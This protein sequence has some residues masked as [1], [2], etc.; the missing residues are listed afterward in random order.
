MRHF[1][2]VRII[3]A[4]TQT[5]TD[6]NLEVRKAV[7]KSLLAQ[8][9]EHASKGLVVLLGDDSHSVWADAAK[10]ILNLGPK[11]KASLEEALKHKKR[12]VRTRAATLLC[13]PEI[14]E[15]SSKPFSLNTTFTPYL[16]DALYDDPSYHLYIARMLGRINGDEFSHAMGLIYQGHSQAVY[17]L[18]RLLQLGEWKHLSLLSD[19]LKHITRHM[20]RSEARAVLKVLKDTA[21][22]QRKE[23]NDGFCKIHYSRFIKQDHKSGI[24]YLGC[25]TCKS[26]LVWCPSTKGDTGYGYLYETLCRYVS[27]R[28]IC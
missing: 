28:I 15:D 5:S 23:V 9:H 18:G 12:I 14:H 25:R 22:K 8:N 2:D 7:V 20:D 19:K 27:I 6:A 11:S 1:K 13:R 17:L 16:L 10:G 26:Y 24:D 21:K 4:L 3:E